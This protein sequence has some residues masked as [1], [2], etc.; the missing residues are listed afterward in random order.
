VKAIAAIFATREEAGNA[1]RE[2][3]RI[4]FAG[5]EVV[6]L[7]PG[8]SPARVEAVPSEDAEQ[9][10]MGKAIGSVV[11]GAVG[12]S[13]GVLLGGLVLPGIGP[14]LAVTLGAAA[15]GVG[16]AVAGGIAGNAF[17]ELMSRGLP[18]D[19]LFF[20][21]DAL[22][23]G[24]SVL[25]AFS[26]N[27]DYIASARGMLQ[28]CGAE[29]IDA[30][31][32]KWWIGLRDAEQSSYTGPDEFA[33]DETLYRRGFTAALEPEARGR[34]YE[35]AAEYLET[36]YPEECGEDCFRRG[37]ERGRDYYRHNVKE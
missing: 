18:K 19:E 26:D 22:R 29:M 16:G 5:Q 14:V 13:A 25:I 20:Y 17:E 35:E 12:L 15:V 31:R 24:D 23:R 37:F 28:R 30:A 8:D 33:R 11:G 7:S 36:R 4:G 2:L 1:G 3:Q 21:E 32:D 34:S 10:G 27:D 9:L 6:I